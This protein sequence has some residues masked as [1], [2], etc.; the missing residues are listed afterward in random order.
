MESGKMATSEQTPLAYDEWEIIV[1]EGAFEE[2]LVAL[3]D[4]V[5]LLETGTLRLDD[6]V[7][8]FEVGSRLARRCQRLLDEAE[9][10][11]TTLDDDSDG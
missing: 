10:R 5:A 2:S 6:A 7:R 1:R 11:I 9:L 8:C 3:R 4:V